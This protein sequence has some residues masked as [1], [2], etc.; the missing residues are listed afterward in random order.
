MQPMTNDI[1]P[2]LFIQ[3]SSWVFNQKCLHHQGEGKGLEMSGN[4]F[5]NPISYHSQWLIPIFI[6]NPKF[7]LV[8]FPFPSHSHWLFPFNPAP[9][10]VLLVV[11]RS[12]NK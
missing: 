3:I 4:I 2:I 11:S 10:P 1:R 5:F 12:E 6:P 8:L 7:S 9:I